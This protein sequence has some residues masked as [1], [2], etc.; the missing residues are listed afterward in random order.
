MVVVVVTSMFVLADSGS[1]EASAA[2]SA[3]VAAADVAALPGAV[4]SDPRW[5][6]SIANRKVLDQHGDVY[7]IRT[8]SS[9]AMASNL[10][11]ADITSALQALAAHGFNG[12]TVWIGGGADYGSDWSPRYQHKS[13]RQNF[14]TGTPWASSL[15]PAWGSLDHLV[16]EAERLGIVVWMSLNGGFGTYGARA[17]WEAVGDSDMYD[18]GVAVA[19]R[20]RSSPN[21]G[22]HVMFDDTSS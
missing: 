1:G 18:A 3:G 5:P 20:Y 8:F 2:T 16:S 15:G 7:L 21:V 12:V 19:A 9:W 11:D 17:D 14:W 10:S 13:T 22:W 6:S 4:S